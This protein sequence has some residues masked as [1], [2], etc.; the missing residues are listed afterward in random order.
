M[1]TY[2]LQ[3]SCTPYRWINQLGSLI[4]S[5]H[6]R[7]NLLNALSA[8]IVLLSPH[9]FIADEHDSAFNHTTLRSEISESPT[10]QADDLK[11]LNQAYEQ[12]KVLAVSRFVTYTIRNPASTP[13]ELYDLDLRYR[14][15]DEKEDF[16]HR[17]ELRVKPGAEIDYEA[18]SPLKTIQFI[19]DAHVKSEADIRRLVH[20]TEL[21]DALSRAD[22]LQTVSSLEVILA[23]QNF[24]EPPEVRPA[25]QPTANQNRGWILRHN[26]A[27]GVVTVRMTSMFR[28]PETQSLFSKPDAE[29]IE[30]HEYDGYSPDFGRIYRRVGDTDSDSNLLLDNHPSQNG[31]IVNV[32]SDSE[33]LYITPVTGSRAGTRKV[34]IYIRGW[35]SRGPTS[36]QPSIDPASSNELAKITAYIQTG[37]NKPPRWPGNAT[38]FNSV[39]SEGQIDQ[40]TPDFGA[41]SASDPEGSYVTHTFRNAGNSGTCSD[42]RQGL[43]VNFAG[44]CFRIDEAATTVSVE[45]EIDYEKVKDNPV[46]HFALLATDAM[47]AVSEA[48]FFVRVQD[49]NEPISGAFPTNAVSIHLPTT[50]TRSIDLSTIFRDPEEVETITF[51]ASS[52]N[53]NFVTVNPNPNPILEITAHR[54]GRANLQVQAIGQFS[55]AFASLVVHVR[56]T[57]TPPSFSGEAVSLGFGVTEN[58]PLGT[59]FGSV[60]EATDED[61]GDTLT[62]TL[63]QNTTF[64]LTNAGLQPNQVQLITK[65]PINYE[66]QNQYKLKL[67]VSDGVDVKTIDLNVLV[68]NLDEEVTATLE[69]I[70]T[71][72]VDIGT[73]EILNI[74]GHFYD[75]DGRLPDISAL[76]FD[77]RIASVFV[78]DGT[79]IHVVGEAVGSTQVTLVA[80]DTLGSAASKTFTVVVSPNRP[81]VINES[82]P[83]QEI[84]PGLLE[85]SIKELFSD[86]DS[87]FSIISATSSNEDVLWVIRPKGEPDTLILY[88]WMVGEADVTLIAEDSSENQVFYTF[89]VKVVEEESDTPPTPPID[90]NQLI[91]NQ[92]VGV[93]TQLGTVSLLAVF[94]TESTDPI[95]YQIES[96]KPNTVHAMLARGDVVGWWDSLTCMQKIAVVEDGSAATTDNPYCRRFTALSAQKRIVVRALA[97]HYLLIDGLAL[98]S[99]TIT[100]TASFDELPEV[101]TSFETTV[102]TRVASSRVPRSILE[103][104]LYQGESKKISLSQ[105]LD[106]RS[107][108]KTAQSTQLLIQNQSLVEASLSG[109][110]FTLQLE[111]LQEGTTQIALL[112]TNQSNQTVTE[113]INVRVLSPKPAISRTLNELQ[114][115]LGDDPYRMDLRELFTSTLGLTYTA[116]SADSDI[117]SV[118]VDNNAQV[119][120][121]DPLARGATALRLTATDSRGVSANLNVDVVVSDAKLRHSAK[122]ALAAHSLAVLGSAQSVFANRF[123][124]PIEHIKDGSDSQLIES[125]APTNLKVSANQSL[126]W[127]TQASLPPAFDPKTTLGLNFRP[128]PTTNHTTRLPNLSYESKPKHTNT[129]WS[130]WTDTH[131]RSYQSEHNQ[132]QLHSTYLGADIIWG[133]ALQTGIALSQTE[134][135]TNYTY[136]SAQRSQDISQ[137]FVWP[138]A[139]YQTKA[140]HSV[141]GT[142]GLGQGSMQILKDN[143]LDEQLRLKTKATILG[144]NIDLHQLGNVEL[145]WVGDIALLDTYAESRSRPD[146]PIE[147]WVGRVR[148][149][150]TTS[151][152]PIE[153]SPST[154]LTPYAELNLRMDLG[155]LENHAGVELVAGSRLRHRQI[156]L[157]LK[158]HTLLTNEDSAYKEHGFSVVATYNPNQQPTGLAVSLAPSWGSKQRGLG[159][160]DSVMHSMQPSSLGSFDLLATDRCKFSLESNISVGLLSGQEHYVLTP[161]WKLQHADSNQQRLGLRVQGLT[162]ANRNLSLDFSLQTTPYS[163]DSS[164]LGGRLSV[165]LTGL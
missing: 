111:G 126:N 118:L 150:V 110:D 29:D 76:G 165:S 93:G 136:G 4:A 98:G 162:D 89:T 146:D 82:I 57:N 133:N 134:A 62:Y 37:I 101:K 20:P 109:Q 1:R 105:L 96:S 137:T 157:E 142:I 88:A 128:T 30:L 124:K 153:L 144:T 145:G 80:Q 122:Q 149:G 49:V 33:N 130:L 95:G 52:S 129:R 103:V 67:T 91:P 10:L 75:E 17:L 26:A 32:T 61:E 92:S 12:A 94:S 114:L 6:T 66:A 72:Q 108:L 36:I 120:V 53:S 112:S 151:H 81:P 25:F 2:E 127:L 115:E 100:V 86:Q 156:E 8:F 59:V 18:L 148:T 56:D 117:L 3:S 97:S 79:R 15:K 113:R 121:L 47:G 131:S 135:D 31:L 163:Q 87:E 139:R 152:T 155:E 48:N 50:T 71:L 147:T 64:G 161:Y 38:G 73:T 39:V 143:H 63:D 107:L 42:I 7:R 68:S 28:D 123:S 16:S 104:S 23:V 84:N 40:I 154:S 106:S 58:V 13:F 5:R 164:D 44:A 54:L 141:W 14:A 60:I 34:E 41:W 27:D 69:P 125:R 70:E 9:Q 99:S 24:D 22:Q 83:D 158:T 78:R 11:G 77:S 90:T 119:V 159:G 51:T 35:D 65:A 19:I 55:R 132:G 140:G 85:I 21:D 102:V 74:E 160:F 45:G 46:G 138:Y 116:E 43:G